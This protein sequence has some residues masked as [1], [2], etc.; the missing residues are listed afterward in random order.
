MPGM[1]PHVN[2]MTQQIHFLDKMT[3][4]QTDIFLTTQYEETLDETAR[5]QNTVEGLTNIID[6]ALSFSKF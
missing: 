5:K 1:E 6:S 4:T 3:L 2:I